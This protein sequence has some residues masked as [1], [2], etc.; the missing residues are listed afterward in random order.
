MQRKINIHITTNLQA[1]G[2]PVSPASW[3]E[4]SLDENAITKTRG[5]LNA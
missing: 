1:Q 3:L 2:Y 5:V 4:F